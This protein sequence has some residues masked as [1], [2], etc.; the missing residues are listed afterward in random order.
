MLSLFEFSGAMAKP[1]ADAGFLCYCVDMQHPAGESPHP[2]IENVIRVGADL[3][4]WLPPNEGEIVFAAFC[5]PCTDVAVSGARWFPG[6]GIG[7]AVRALSLFMRSAHMAEMMRCPYLIENPV[8]T[9]SSHW[10]KPDYKFQPCD[11]GDP[12][13]K[14]TCLWTGGGFVMPPKKPVKPT[15]GSKMHKVGPGKNRANIRSATPP[16][17]A[18]AVFEANRPNRARV[19]SSGWHDLYRKDGLACAVTG[20]T[21]FVGKAHLKPLPTCT[22]AQRKDPSNQ[23]ALTS[24]L[25]ALLDLGLLT[26]EDDGR[27]LL[28]EKLGAKERQQFQF[29]A[30][31]RDM[32]NAPAPRYLRYHRENCFVG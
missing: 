21:L 24:Q 28:S 2:K 1:W 30:M 11:Y 12:Y 9:I 26:F 32:H 3:L 20:S 18:R 10:R 29:P 19:P 14:K 8:A 6:K 25:H 17:F 16:G 15:L 13:T 31:I 23:I 5:P 4:E 7:A 27:I 22:A